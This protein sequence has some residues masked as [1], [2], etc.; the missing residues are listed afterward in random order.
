MRVRVKNN[1]Y[2]DIV[3]KRNKEV[4]TCIGAH[5][6]RENRIVCYVSFDCVCGEILVVETTTTNEGRWLT[7]L[8]F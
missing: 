2:I 7:C 3:S 5:W 1:C 6:E 4:I 8:W